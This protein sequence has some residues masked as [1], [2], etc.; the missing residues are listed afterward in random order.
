MTRRDLLTC[1]RYSRYPEVTQE[2]LPPLDLPYQDGVIVAGP[3]APCVCGGIARPNVTPVEFI[4]ADVDR[5]TGI[6]M[7][8]VRRDHVATVVI[9]HRFIPLPRTA[10][11]LVV[12]THVRRERAAAGLDTGIVTTVVRPAADECDGFIVVGHRV[13]VP[14]DPAGRPDQVVWE[15]MRP[16]QFAAWRDR[17]R[18]PR[19]GGGD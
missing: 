15:L 11:T 4:P 19:P 2:H 9:H 12:S 8:M 13:V 3:S 17:E 14:D 1:R 7:R 10:L 5:L 16:G 6:A 18:G